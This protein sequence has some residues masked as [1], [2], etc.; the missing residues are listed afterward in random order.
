MNS[1]IKLTY[2]DRQDFVHELKL[3]RRDLQE[4]FYQCLSV[5][6]TKRLLIHA[7]LITMTKGGLTC[8]A[9]PQFLDAL[10]LRT[11]TTV[12]DEIEWHTWRQSGPTLGKQIEVRDAAGRTQLE[13]P[14]SGVEID[15]LM[16]RGYVDWRYL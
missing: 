12:A 11:A 8:P 15:S 14:T 3:L 2:K 9:T 6:A 1:E 4:G 13:H 16:Q 10:L 5:N 7:P